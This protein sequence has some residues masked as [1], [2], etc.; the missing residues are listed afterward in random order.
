[1]GDKSPRLFVSISC[2]ANCRGSANRTTLPQP[3][4]LGKRLGAKL[5]RPYGCEQAD[6]MTS[7]KVMPAFNA[8]AMVVLRPLEHETTNMT[9]G[10]DSTLAG[11]LGFQRRA[12]CGRDDRNGRFRPVVTASEY[13][14]SASW[15]AELNGRDRPVAGQ[16]IFE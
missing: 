7:Q 5:V 15:Y 10:R 9:I 3:M 11:C 13:F 14:I 6:G 8:S 12:A 4:N 16:H 2:T 1:M